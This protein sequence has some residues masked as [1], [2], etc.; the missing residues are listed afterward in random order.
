MIHKYLSLAVGVGVMLLGAVLIVTH[1]RSRQRHLADASLDDRERDYFR[2]QFRRRMMA[3]SLLTLIGILIPLGDELIVPWERFQRAWAIYWILVL[4]LVLC[5]L[6]FA[7]L[8]WLATGA[9]VRKSR[10]AIAKLERAQQELQEELQRL[11]DRRDSD[12]PSSTRQNGHI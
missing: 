11:R 2:R 6:M 8:D 10:N 5:V 4:L 9:H 12:G 7:A 3:S 1:F